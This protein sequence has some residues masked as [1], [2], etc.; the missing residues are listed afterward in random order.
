MVA[1]P[2]PYGSSG[3]LPGF[4]A[5]VDAYLTPLVCVRCASVRRFRCG[6]AWNLARCSILVRENFVNQA[7]LNRLLRSQ[8]VVAVSILLDAL[9][10]LASVTSQDVVDAAAQA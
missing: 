9:A 4:Q 5:S 8:E 3:L 7:I 1:R 10:R 2:R 6:V